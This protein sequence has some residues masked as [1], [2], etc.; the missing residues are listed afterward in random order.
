MPGHIGLLKRI[1]ASRVTTWREEL[2]PVMVGLIEVAAGRW[3]EQRNYLRSAR[4][5]APIGALRLVGLEAIWR[6]DELRRVFL[7]TSRRIF[8]TARNLLL[9]WESCLGRRVLEAG[10]AAQSHR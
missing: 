10:A 4:E 2:P 1:N 6:Y 8:W 7:L 9:Y 5:Q 3:L